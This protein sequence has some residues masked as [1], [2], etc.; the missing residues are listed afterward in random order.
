MVS[1]LLEAGAD[2]NSDCKQVMEVAGMMV[3]KTG[4]MNAT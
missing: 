3:E 2:L 4:T 1:L